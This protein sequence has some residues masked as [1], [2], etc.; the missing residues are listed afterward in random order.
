MFLYVT[1][2]LQ[3]TLHRAFPS[4]HT[5]A[6]HHCPP[7]P[8]HAP[9]AILKIK[10]GHKQILASV[11]LPASAHLLSPLVLSTCFPRLTFLGTKPST[12]IRKSAACLRMLHPG[13]DSCGSQGPPMKPRGS[14]GVDAQHVSP[15]Q[16]TLCSLHIPPLL[17][18]SMIF[19]LFGL[20]FSQGSDQCLG[21]YSTF[22]L[23]F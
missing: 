3:K 1:R 13:R 17:S 6:K 4:D 22:S 7:P 19:P 11:S 21:A 10:S 18:S 12:P 5:L 9:K 2:L 8:R 16:D 14:P 20:G 23:F 15:V